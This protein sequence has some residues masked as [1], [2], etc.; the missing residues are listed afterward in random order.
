MVNIYVN[1]I[2]YG[3]KTLDDVPMRLR[4]AVEAKL[5]ELNI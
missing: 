2:I 5:R 4:M 3:L 1:L